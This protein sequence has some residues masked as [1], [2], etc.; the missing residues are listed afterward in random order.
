[1]EMA[2]SMCHSFAPTSSTILI[3]SP[4]LKRQPSNLKGEH[5]RY[6]FFSSSLNSKPPSVM[7]TALRAFTVF[8]SLPI[9]V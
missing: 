8:S 4:V 7:M 2:M 6:W 9:M 5:L 1:M 3:P